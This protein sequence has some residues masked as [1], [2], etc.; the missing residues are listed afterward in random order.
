MIEQAG[1]SGLLSASMMPIN[2]VDAQDNESFIIKTV[3][4]AVEKNGLRMKRLA[5]CG[6]RHCPPTM[7]VGAG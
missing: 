5:V 2:P 4:K 3:P 7:T 6:E 1:N